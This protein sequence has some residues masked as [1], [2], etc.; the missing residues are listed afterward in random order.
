MKIWDFSWSRYFTIFLYFMIN[1]L[2]PNPTSPEDLWGHDPT[3]HPSLLRLGLCLG[4]LRGHELGERIRSTRLCQAIAMWIALVI[5]QKTMENQWKS[6][7]IT[8]LVMGKL[9]L[10]TGPF[11]IA[12]LNYQIIMGSSFN[13][14]SNSRILRDL[15]LVSDKA[16]RIPKPKTWL[17]QT[18]FCLWTN[19]AYPLTC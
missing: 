4:R 5:S 18:R 17:L 1:D 13:Q 12:M 3:K 9:T 7:S 19:L 10:S 6:W 16:T 15:G 8:M 2:G 14:P 11:S